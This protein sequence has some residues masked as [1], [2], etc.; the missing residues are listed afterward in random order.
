[1][2]FEHRV[3]DGLL[4]EWGT[5]EDRQLGKSYYPS[6]TPLWRYAK[7]GAPGAP[8][9]GPVELHYGTPRKILKVREAIQ[10][11]PTTQQAIVYVWYVIHQTERGVVLTGQKKA[12]ALGMNYSTMKTALVRARESLIAMIY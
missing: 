12:E 1:M 7:E 2:R 10:K 11:L 8:V 4:N 3:I 6:I 9:F 5:Y